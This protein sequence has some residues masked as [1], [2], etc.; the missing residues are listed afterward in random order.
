MLTTAQ[1]RLLF[2]I[3]FVVYVPVLFLGTHWPKLEVPGE[4][5]PDLLVHLVAFGL[6]AGLLIGCGFFGPSLSWRNITRVFVIAAVYAAFDEATQAIPFLH[7]HAAFDDYVANL[8]GILLACGGAAVL[9]K[10]REG[11]LARQQQQ[12]N[13]A[14]EHRT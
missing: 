11:R 14:A 5:R 12:V 10:V 1:L 13:T 9:M 6:W 4:G 2:R 7:R 3:A 8:V